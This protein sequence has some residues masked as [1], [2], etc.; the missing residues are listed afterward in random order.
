MRSSR[1]QNWTGQIETT[2]D[3]RDSSV[4]YENILALSGG[5]WRDAIVGYN[6]DWPAAMLQLQAS[7]EGGKGPGPANDCHQC[8]SKT[9]SR[10]GL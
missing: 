9:A 2:R 6:T 5:G 1:P 4:R 10:G 7:K 8:H 3:R